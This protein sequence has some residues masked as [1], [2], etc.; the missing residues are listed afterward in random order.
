MTGRKAPIA[1][2][3]LNPQQEAPDIE[4][5]PRARRHADRQITAQVGFAKPRGPQTTLA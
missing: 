2:G 3:S 5:A 4:I 1:T